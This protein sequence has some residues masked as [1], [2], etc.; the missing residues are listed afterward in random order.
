MEPYSG[1]AAE[2]RFEPAAAPNGTGGGQEAVTNVFSQ[3]MIRRDLEHIKRNIRATA[4]RP[5]TC[6]WNNKD[7]IEK[8]INWAMIS[9]SI[10]WWEFDVF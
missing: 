4:F 3:V 10:P 9:A 8:V 7:F 1:G 2:A 6:T 5:N